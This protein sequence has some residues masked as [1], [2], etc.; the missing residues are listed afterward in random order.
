VTVFK[1]LYGNKFPKAVAKITGDVE[2]L[3]A[4]YDYPA[5]HWIHLRTTN[6][7]ESTFAT[8]RQRVGPSHQGARFQCGRAGDGVQAHRVSTGPLAR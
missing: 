7:I 1:A 8:V 5:Q 4:F 6:P 2:E 3:L